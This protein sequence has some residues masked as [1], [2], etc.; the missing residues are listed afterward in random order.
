M[1]ALIQRVSSASVTVAGD[2]AGEIG[3]GFLVLVCAMQGD[4]AAEADWLA[5]KV[6][7][8]R[9]FEDDEGRMNRSLLEVGGAALIVSQFTLAAE[10]RRNRPGFSRAAAPEY[11][12]RLYEQFSAAVAGHGVAVGNG[13][14]GADMQVALVNDGPVTIWL[15]TAAR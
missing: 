4:T 8:L 10:T 15:D 12:R 3:A 9:I 6:V 13:V 5:R 11:G 2:V 1:R 7:N 14:F